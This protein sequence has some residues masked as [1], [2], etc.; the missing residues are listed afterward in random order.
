MPFTTRISIQNLD[1]Q[2]YLEILRL[3]RENRDLMNHNIANT[4]SF[5]IVYPPEETFY[6]TFHQKIGKKNTLSIR[7]IHFRNPDNLVLNRVVWV[8]NNRKPSGDHFYQLSRDLLIDRFQN[9]FN[10]LPPD[11]IN[12]YQLEQSRF[13]HDMFIGALDQPKLERVYTDILGS[14]T[15]FRSEN[16]SRGLYNQVDDLNNYL[17]NLSNLAHNNNYCDSYPYNSCGATSFSVNFLGISV[18]ILTTGHKIR[19]IGEGEMLTTNQR[20]ENFFAFAFNENN[21]NLTKEVPQINIS[22]QS[23]TQLIFHLAKRSAGNGLNISDTLIYEMFNILN[24]PGFEGF[25][26]H[27]TDRNNKFTPTLNLPSFTTQSYTELVRNLTSNIPISQAS[28][29]FRAVQGMDFQGMNLNIL[30]SIIDRN[31]PLAAVPQNDFFSPKINFL[32]IEVVMNYA[33]NRIA[34]IAETELDYGQGNRPNNFP[35]IAFT[36]NGNQITLTPTP[37]QGD[38][39]TINNYIQLIIYLGDRRAGNHIIISNTLIYELLNHDNL[40][41]FTVFFNHTID[42]KFKFSGSYETIK[43]TQQN[44]HI[45]HYL[46][47]ILDEDDPDASISTSIFKTIGLTGTN[48]TEL[49]AEVSTRITSF[50]GMPITYTEENITTINGNDYVHT[51]NVTILQNQ[52][53]IAAYPRPAVAQPPQNNPNLPLVNIN[54]N[55]EDTNIN[56]SPTSFHLQKYIFNRRT[57]NE[58]LRSNDIIHTLL[59]PANLNASIGIVAILNRNLDYINH[60]YNQATRDKL[61][62]IHFGILNEA[63][64]RYVLEQMRVN[65]RYWDSS[66]NERIANRDQYDY[67]IYFS[68]MDSI[69]WFSFT[70]V[71]SGSM[72]G[73]FNGYQY[74]KNN[75]D[76]DITAP[77]K[78]GGLIDDYTLNDLINND[79]NLE[80]SPNFLSTHGSA[81]ILFT[82]EAARDKEAEE[83]NVCFI[84]DYLNKKSQ[85]HPE[86]LNF[87]LE[88]MHGVFGE[89]YTAT[90]KNY[91]VQNNVRQHT[92]GGNSARNPNRILFYNPLPRA[93]R[94]SFFTEPYILGDFSSEKTTLTKL[95]TDVE[96]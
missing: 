28:I 20:P 38:P 78:Y 2:G 85:E 12:E 4:S 84:K 59:N 68:W 37:A 89:N 56:E 19:K 60:G 16:T 87:E 48:I 69:E 52:L 77:Y 29:R 26:A 39:I 49:R 63:N 94:L 5:F 73:N 40:Q 15:I 46:T 51:N 25:M 31:N 80:K 44:F 66:N 79:G 74:K 42:T 83:I 41:N 3:I 43:E 96:L 18:V 86:Y 14:R 17:S 30:N 34:S 22:I 75:I 93:A 32:G 55:G 21:I 70:G 90:K 33:N 71:K 67:K 23:Y 13:L 24:R 76:G 58:I 65:E 62:N 7:S 10:L 57:A 6:I 72:K 9:L 45:K 95:L 54:H 91:D 8:K 81:I 82:S 35:T 36:Q 47:E 53:N 1:E 64:Y 50:L 61:L 27:M 92:T 88:T 11:N